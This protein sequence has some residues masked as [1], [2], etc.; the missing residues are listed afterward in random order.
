[1]EAASSACHDP[2][3]PPLAEKEL[4]NIVVEVSVLTVPQEIKVE[5][6][7]ELPKMIEIGRDGLIMEKGF[8]RGL[9]LPQV[10]VEWGWDAEQ[11]LEQTC[12]KAGLSP[13]SWLDP[14]VKILSFSAEVFAEDTPRGKV[15]RKRLV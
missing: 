11:F 7:R 14:K 9:L 3:F 6:R 8:R 15:V 12:H 1:M 13:D 2:R 10:P 4:D 5:Q